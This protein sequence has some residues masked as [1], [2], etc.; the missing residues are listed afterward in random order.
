MILHVVLY[1]PKASAT[2]EELSELASALEAASR[3]IPSIKQVRVG[4]AVD[5]GFG[6]SNWPK[7]QNNGNVAVFEFIDRPALEAY[8]AHESH[9]RLA[10]AFWNTCNQPL[11]IDV[12][13]L[14][15]SVDDMNAV[16]GQSIK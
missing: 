1:Q 3:G 15:P 12:S 14:D 9:K 7:D 6:Y 4:K 16:F 2:R 10:A 5:F 8:L 13:A 11:I